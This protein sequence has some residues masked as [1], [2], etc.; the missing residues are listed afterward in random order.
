MKRY[1]IFILYIGLAGLYGQVDSSEVYRQQGYQAKLA[2]DYALSI[3]YYQEVLERKPNEYDATLAIARLHALQAAHDSAVA[4]F[5]RLL[6]RDPRDW[7]ALHG[8]GDCR[9]QQGKLEQAIAYHRQAVEVLPTHVPGY[10]A[11]A[12]ALS[13]KGKLDEAIE[14]YQQANQQDSTYA[15]VWAGLGKMYYWK[16]KPYTASAYYERA[17]KLD[18]THAPTRRAYQKI[19]RDTQAWLKGQL[20]FFQEKEQAYVINALIQQYT[21]SK[22]LSDHLHL[23]LN[24]LFDYSN[25]DFSVLDD[26]DTTRWFLNSWAKLS[27]IEAHHRLDVYVGYSPTDQLLSSYGLSWQM[28]YQWGDFGISNT[29]N[30]GY[31][32]FFYWNNVGRHILNESLQLK[33][34]R[35]EANLGLSLGRVDEKPIR[36]Y[37]DQEYEAGSNPLQIYSFSLNYQVLNNPIVKVG[38]QYSLMDFEYQ[39]PDYY[40]PYDRNLAGLGTSVRKKFKRWYFYGSFNYNI[41]NETFFFLSDKP[42]VAY[43]TGKVEVDNW[44]AGLEIGYT[45]PGFSLS[46]GGSR[47]QNPFYEN[48]IG[49]LSLSKSL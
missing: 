47:F 33:W 11:L 41:G 21:F 1:L 27:W 26:N 25:R 29:L 22:R 10:L 38:L 31:E 36:K 7:E 28:K 13:W 14:V 46:I 39:S 19:Q 3:R 12:K 9:L 30:A 32:Y 44:S 35:W 6:D 43:E 2:G 18:P 17:L 16:G 24:S 34:K 37:S 8:I 15:E 45:L 40:S 42:E 4:Y 48:G 20:R 49:F 5:Q 23:Q